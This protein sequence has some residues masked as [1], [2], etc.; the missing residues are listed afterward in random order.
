MQPNTRAVFTEAP[1]SL[2][3]EMQ[4]I[5][6][7]A[8]AAHKH[9]ALVLMDNTWAS[10]LYFKALEKGVDLSIQSGTKYIGGHSDLMLGTVSANKDDRRSG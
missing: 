2:T 9:G 8:E 1:G 4:D 7:I 3:F 10:P 6:A 5:P